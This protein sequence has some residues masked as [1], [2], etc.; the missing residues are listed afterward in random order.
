LP[1]SRDDAAA[2]DTVAQ[3]LISARNGSATAANVIELRTANA[4]HF[5]CRLFDPHHADG[6]DLRSA[7]RKR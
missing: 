5:T 3:P 1:A 4:Q 6:I 7:R 2:T